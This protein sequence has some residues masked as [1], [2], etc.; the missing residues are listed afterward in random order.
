MIRG[1]L[2]GS[3]SFS[4]LIAPLALAQAPL[5]ASPLQ[6][7]VA[8]CSGRESGASC[9]LQHKGRTLNGRCRRV[10]GGTLACAPG[11]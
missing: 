5:P 4:L 3:A 10:L 8:V 6:Q 2:S 1:L 11:R 9:A 7:A